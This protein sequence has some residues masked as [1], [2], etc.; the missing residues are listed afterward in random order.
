MGMSK[1]WLG[2]ITGHDS[3]KS[4]RR[5]QP[6][7]TSDDPYDHIATYLAQT[8]K[9]VLFDVGANV[10]QT[11]LR[12]RH[13]FPDGIIHSF[14]PSPDTFKSL[15][16]N[17]GRTGNTVLNNVGVGATSGTLELI[18]NTKSDMSSFLEPA[19]TWGAVR[20]RTSVPVITVDEYCLINSIDRIDLLKVDTQGYDYEV[21]LGS[22]EMLRR[23]TIALILVE[24]IFDTMYNDIRRFDD[25]LYLLRAA[26]TARGIHV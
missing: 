8:P 2:R 11:V 18:E 16:S 4:F 24:V 14:E 19:D 23:R 6:L 3:R 20:K 5:P 7:S 25:L 13:L 10:G 21:L 22:A 1:S 17:V 15:E 12:L 26:Q 9:P